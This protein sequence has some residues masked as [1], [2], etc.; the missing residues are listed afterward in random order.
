MPKL[1]I[2]EWAAQQ[3]ISKV[4]AYKRVDRGVVT[5]DENRMVDVEQAEAEWTRNKNV[6]EAAKNPGGRKKVDRLAAAKH[7]EPRA[8]G[9]TDPVPD[10]QSFFEAQRR[11]EWIKVQREQ[12]ALDVTKGSLLPVEEVELQWSRMIGAARNQLLLLPD[13]VAPRVAIL[14]DVLEC[15]ELIRREVAQALEALSEPEE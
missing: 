10:A 5:V 8:E 6:R 2:P 13:R 15:R 1:S 4:A 14:S 7:S 11:R 12:L 9:N 3:G